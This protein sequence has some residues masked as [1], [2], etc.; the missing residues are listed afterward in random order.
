MTQGEIY[1]FNS[2]FEYGRCGSLASCPWPPASRERI[3]WMNGYY[4]GSKLRR[5]GR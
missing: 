1:I 2:G 5:Y 3:V 4:E